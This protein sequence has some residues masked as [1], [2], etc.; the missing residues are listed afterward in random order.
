MDD[1]RA[2]GFGQFEA[3]S[4]ALLDGVPRISIR[5][6]DFTYGPGLVEA[7]KN[8]TLDIPDRRVTGMI[9]PSGC[10]K[11]TLLRVLN[12]MYSLYPGQEATGEVLLDGENLLDPATEPARIR[13]MFVRG[14]WTRR[15]LGREIL[16]ASERAAGAEG[17]RTPHRSAHRPG[18]PAA[19][20]QVRTRTIGSKARAAST[21][22][23]AR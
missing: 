5:G 19:N 2:H 4:E 12:R 17:L 11:S 16:D 7:L 22:G 1:T 10:G 14:D 20:S 6:L 9:G 15:G 21:S 13:A 3:R 23:S 8:I 18:C